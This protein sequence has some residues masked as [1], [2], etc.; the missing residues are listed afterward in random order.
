MPHYHHPDRTAFPSAED[1]TEGMSLRMWLLGQSLTGLLSR[2]PLPIVLDDA[3]L[4]RVVDAAVKCADLTITAANRGRADPNA[5][6]PPPN[7]TVDPEE[8]F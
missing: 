3:S 6:I 2:F 5:P 8:P 1:A 7:R 4:Q